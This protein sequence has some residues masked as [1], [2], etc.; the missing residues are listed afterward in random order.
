MIHDLTQAQ[1]DLLRR[2]AD[3]PHGSLWIDGADVLAAKRM[4]AAAFVEVDD[5]GEPH[6]SDCRHSPGGFPDRYH[7]TITGGGRD[8]LATLIDLAALTP[9][10]ATLLV[11]LSRGGARFIRGAEVRAAKRLADL[12]YAS[13]EDN[14]YLPHNWERWLAA[15]THAGRAR[16][17]AMPKEQERR[18]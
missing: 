16:A 14:G 9:S 6:P 11:R 7:A 1:I 18:T 15:A 13:L 8:Y 5:E 10:Q 4:E 3:D 17:A 12:G 2:L